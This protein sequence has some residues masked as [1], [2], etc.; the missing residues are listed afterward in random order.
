MIGS[1]FLQARVLCFQFL[2]LCTLFLKSRFVDRKPVGLRAFGIILTNKID[3]FGAIRTPGPLTVA[4]E[5]DQKIAHQTRIADML[6]LVFLFLHSWQATLVM[7]AR[8]LGT[9]LDDELGVPGFADVG[10]PSLDNRAGRIGLCRPSSS[11]PSI[12]I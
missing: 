12:L 11:G 7:G 10:D 1:R 9:R 3:S 8:L 2:D 5:L 6:T 4:L